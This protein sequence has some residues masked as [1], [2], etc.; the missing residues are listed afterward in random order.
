MERAFAHADVSM[1]WHSFGS[2]L[3]LPKIA[4]FTMS[5]CSGNKAAPVVPG[6][7]DNRSSNSRNETIHAARY[8]AGSLKLHSLK[9]VSGFSRL[10]SLIHAFR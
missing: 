4:V 10:S 5:G 8:S 9:S 7:L 3:R 6:H 2:D 1:E